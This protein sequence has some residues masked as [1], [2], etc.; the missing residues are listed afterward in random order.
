MINNNLDKYGKLVASEYLKNGTDLNESITKIA[1][2][3]SLNRYEINRLIESANTNTYLNLFSNAE[4]KYIKFDVAD[5]EKVAA[6][7]KQS[8][9]FVSSNT[10]DEYSEPPA[11]SGSSVEIS[12]FKTA[13]FDQEP[14]R[15]AEQHKLK[16]RAS[17]ANDYMLAKI[18]QV[19]NSFEESTEKFYFMVKQAVLGGT[20]FGDIKNMVLNSIDTENLDTHKLAS[21]LL[22]QSKERLRKEDR[23][24]NLEDN[25]KTAAL[26]PNKDNSLV[27]QFNEIEKLAQEAIEWRDK[28]AGFW[29]ITKDILRRGVETSRGVAE[30]ILHYPKLWAG[31]GASA[32]AGTV[33][34]QAGKAKQQKETSLLNRTPKGY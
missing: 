31:A 33:G 25:E 5:Y 10:F 12:I 3:N 7:L 28:Y 2:E 32:A 9:D 30:S 13:S 24:L 21:V 26:Q 14:S 18:A 22:T 11:H 6:N 27:R 8:S 34:Y 4:D 20:R 17:Y 16:Q 19:D 29:S 1:Q 15:A 23:L